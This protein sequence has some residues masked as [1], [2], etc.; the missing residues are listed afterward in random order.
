MH[1]RH[2]WRWAIEVTFTKGRNLLWVGQA[3]NRTR[4]VPFGLHCPTIAVV[5]YARLGHHSQDAAEWRERAQW[6]VTK[7]QPSL[8][9]MLAK[10]RQMGEVRRRGLRC[11]CR[12]GGLCGSCTREPA[13]CT[14]RMGLPGLGW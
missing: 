2:A 11:L 7:T 1:G 5:W 9:D 13:W 6:Y 14:R 3:E 12:R 4:T 8:S 10:L